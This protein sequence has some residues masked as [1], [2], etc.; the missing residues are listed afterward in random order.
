M[1]NEAL[2]QRHE[3]VREYF[4]RVDRGGT[5]LADLCTDDVEFY[6]PSSG[7]GAVWTPSASWPDGSISNASSMT[8]LAWTS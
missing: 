4:R 3:V 7:S 5:S 1:S 6:F 8:S 2:A